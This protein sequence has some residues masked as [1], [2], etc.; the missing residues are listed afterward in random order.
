MEFIAGPDGHCYFMEMN[1]RLQ[2]EHPVTEFIT[3][4]DLVEWQLRV[5]GGEPLPLTQEQITL[6]GHA[7]EVRL[8]A[9][10]PERDFLPSAGT[11]R[12]L[13]F[14]AEGPKVRVD[15]GIQAGDVVTIHYD[16]LLA[17]VIVHGTDRD[18]ALRTLRAAL[19][20]T[21]VAGLRTNRDFLVALAS[22]PAFA[23]GAVDTGFIATH[24]A[25]LLRR[26]ATLP[27]AA[28][29]DPWAVRD[30][31][32]LN[33]PAEFGAAAHRT[34]SAVRTA[35]PV[36]GVLTAPMPGQIAAVHVQVGTAVR[37]GDVLLVLEAMKMEH[38]I[39]AP[40]DGVVRCLNVVAGEQ[41][42]E[43][44]ELLVIEPPLQERE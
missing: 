4:Q 10:D 35:V 26:V 33:G 27:A 38:S 18:A 37:R 7:I 31:W 20:D 16:S 15:T 32:R 8:C 19:E 2:V 40:T 6:S 29:G 24:Q 23:A 43:G 28:G 25:E 36:S 30:G 12:A 9:E 1:T 13:A 14:P 5:A 17:K 39:T 42:D 41:V 44:V 21:Q 11:V 22:H 3:G 34:E